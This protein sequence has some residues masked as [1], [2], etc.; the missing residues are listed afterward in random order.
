MF[1]TAELFNAYLRND[2]KA[3]AFQKQFVA[4]LGTD[5]NAGGWNLA[6]PEYVAGVVGA[7]YSGNWFRKLCTVRPPIVR[8]TVT[9]ASR[10]V[11]TSAVVWGEDVPA[12]GPDPSGQPQ[13]GSFTLRP[14]WMSGAFEVSMDLA[15]SANADAVIRGELVAAAGAVEEAAF[16]AGDGIGKPV[17]LFFPSAQGIPTT[18]DVVAD[19]SGI[20]AWTDARR[21]LRA[22]YQRSPGLRWL[23]HP[24]AYAYALKLKSTDGVPLVTRPQ[25]AG[26]P[27]HI[28]GVPV[29]LSDDAPAGTPGD[30]TYA[31][32][33]YLACVGDLSQYDVQDGADLFV[34]RHADSVSMRRGRVLYIFRRK[35]DGCPRVAEAF[36]RLKKA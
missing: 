9:I 8:Q 35:V 15:A 13:F 20:D 27:P 22:V 17:G 33:D 32:G 14:Q 36:V 10:T 7:L 28:D 16:V 1:P 11:Q 12:N 19:P 2:P 23:M 26:D 24:N 18:R 3:A 4:S 21:M 30:G 31:S 6:P 5:P 25:R 29:E 34:T